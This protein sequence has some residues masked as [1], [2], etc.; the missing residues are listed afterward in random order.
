MTSGEKGFILLC[1][2]PVS[3]SVPGIT[4]KIK[5]GLKLDAGRPGIAEDSTTPVPLSVSISAMLYSAF[6]ESAGHEQ[7]R[8]GLR[9]EEVEQPRIGINHVLIR[10]H[11]TG[12]CGTDLHIYKYCRIDASGERDSFYSVVQD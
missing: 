1:L 11:H 3:L 12:I 4:L 5:I 2:R 6:H 8:A 7:K 9:L 10:V